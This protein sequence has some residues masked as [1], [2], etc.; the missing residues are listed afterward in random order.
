MILDIWKAFFE[1]EAISAAGGVTLTDQ[2]SV[3]AFF[4][5]RMAAEGNSIVAVEMKDPSIVVG[6]FLNEDFSN[7]EPEGLR[8]HLKTLEGE[9]IP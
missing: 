3:N 2:R 5:T 8:A 7:P 9:S 1:G 4:C 6:A